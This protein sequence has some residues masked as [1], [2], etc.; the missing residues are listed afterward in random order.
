MGRLTLI[1]LVL[2]SVTAIY[3][4]ANADAAAD[5]DSTLQSLQHAPE[6]RG[7]VARR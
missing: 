6:M 1:I 2:F 4:E 3:S 5:T 7:N